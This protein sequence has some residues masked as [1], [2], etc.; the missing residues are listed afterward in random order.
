LAAVVDEGGVNGRVAFASLLK[1]AQFRKEEKLE[2]ISPSRINPP[3][4]GLA[5][6]F[7]LRASQQP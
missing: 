6:E 7:H 4:W 5:N 2:G 3:R 1:K